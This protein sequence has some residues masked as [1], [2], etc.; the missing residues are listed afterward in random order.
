[1]NIF[2]LYMLF[3]AADDTPL[4]SCRSRPQSLRP[5]HSRCK[6]PLYCILCFQTG[7]CS[8]SEGVFSPSLVFTVLTGRL[9]A[10]PLHQ[11]VLPP[12]SEVQA[13]TLSYH[14][15]SRLT[16]PLANSSHVLQPKKFTA[17]KSRVE[18]TRSCK[19]SYRQN[20]DISYKCHLQ[21]E[22]FP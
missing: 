17:K 5:G 18:Y 19:W 10:E 8:V 6:S 20:L 9:V 4:D 22:T 1:M 14:L 7:I 12:S 21:A 16:A 11:H 15:A 3:S 13:G 2:M